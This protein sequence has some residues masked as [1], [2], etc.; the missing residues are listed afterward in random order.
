MHLLQVS[1][2]QD[3]TDPFNMLRGVQRRGGHSRR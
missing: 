1:S 3:L 2:D